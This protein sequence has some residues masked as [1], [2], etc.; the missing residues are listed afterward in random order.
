M[1]AI[2]FIPD[3]RYLPIFN[4]AL[5]CMRLLIKSVFKPLMRHRLYWYLL[6][7]THIYSRRY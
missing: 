1:A 2:A 3:M 4:T 5:M 7:A 6:V